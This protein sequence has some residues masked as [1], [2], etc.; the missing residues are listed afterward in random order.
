[1]FASSRSNPMRMAV[2]YAMQS[3]II[4]LLSLQDSLFLCYF[5]SLCFSISPYL[6]FA[7]VFYSFFESA[8][9]FSTF[10]E[11]VMLFLGSTH[12]SRFTLGELLE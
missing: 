10:F 4:S 7:N 5:S 3:K 6:D 11:I 9:L 2:L 1:M 8:L 12:P